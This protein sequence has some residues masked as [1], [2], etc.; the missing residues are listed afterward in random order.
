VNDL[1]RLRKVVAVDVE[2]DI[3]DMP[4]VFITLCGL[5]ALEWW[6]RRRKGMS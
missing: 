6:V 2:Q 5:L 4:I 1:K 3:W